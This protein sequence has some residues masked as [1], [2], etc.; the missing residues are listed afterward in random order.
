MSER[1][2]RIA[3]PLTAVLFVGLTLVAFFAGINTPGVKASGA[4]VIA[5]FA[6]HRHSERVIDIIAVFASLM[7]VFFG[8]A[9]RDFLRRDQRS[10]AASALVLAGAVLVAAGFSV[11]IGID[12]AITQVPRHLTPGAAQRLNLLDNDVF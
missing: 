6:T 7:M 3:L 4:H 5:V 10:E 8:A 2:G 9:L 11:V 12:F 1:L